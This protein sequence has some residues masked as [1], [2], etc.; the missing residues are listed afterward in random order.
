MRLGRPRP[1]YIKEEREEAGGHEGARQGGVQLGFPI[2]VGLP[3][4]FQE[5][6]GGKE[7]ERKRKEGATPPPPS[8]I[9]TAL[10]GA[11][12]WPSLSFSLTSH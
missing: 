3:F 5:G 11:T 10:G 7:M 1:P 9:R 4:L 2:L 6:E 8:P 12:L